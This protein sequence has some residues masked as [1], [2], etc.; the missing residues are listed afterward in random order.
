MEPKLLVPE[1]SHEAQYGLRISQQ[2]F[3]C[4][5]SYKM[6]HCIDGKV[7][8]ILKLESVSSDAIYV[9]NTA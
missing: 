6:A 5:L 3:S 2:K 4:H 1:E 9:S 8:N 7:S